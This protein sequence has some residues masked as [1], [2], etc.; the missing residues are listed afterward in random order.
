M[1]SQ[2]TPSSKC[3]KLLVAHSSLT[4]ITREVANRPVS[5][6][7]Q[8]VTSTLPNHETVLAL[9]HSTGQPIWC[10]T[11]KWHSV[12]SARS[13]SSTS[14]VAKS[15]K[16]V[17]WPWV[18]DKAPFLAT[19]ASSTWKHH[20]LRARGSLKARLTFLAS[21]SSITLVKLSRRVRTLTL[22]RVNTQC[23]SC[24]TPDLSMSRSPISPTLTSYSTRWTNHTWSM[25]RHR[26]TILL[27]RS[28]LATLPLYIQLSWVT[29][30][31]KIG[32]LSR[33]WSKT[34]LQGHLI[35]NST[36]GII[37][38]AW[39]PSCEKSSHWP[40]NYFKF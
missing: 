11:D 25:V 33:K 32:V 19:P 9:T 38:L 35:N 27:E 31:C 29:F 36:Q 23:Y 2:R 7:P 12:N 26:E 18:R 40:K 13:T 10:S 34:L 20:H 30:S 8:T 14:M 3:F 24:L 16:I 39:T 1:L 28:S 4:T 15:S 22:I 21:S 5:T 37:T 17:I 6:T